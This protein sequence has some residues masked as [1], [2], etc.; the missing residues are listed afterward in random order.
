MIF[1]PLELV[2]KL[3]ALVPPPRFNLVRYPDANSISTGVLMVLRSRARRLFIWLINGVRR[4]SQVTLLSTDGQIMR[5]Y[6][7]LGHIGTGA[8]RAMAA[9]LDGDGRKEI[10]LAGVSNPRNMATLVIL[11]PDDFGGAATEAPEDQLLGFAPGREIAKL[12][13]PPTCL[14][15]ALQL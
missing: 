15:A 8:A 6:W 9:D 1:E 10:Y 5:E 4:I 13:F 14:S 3:A 11:D 2:E 12:F 7:H